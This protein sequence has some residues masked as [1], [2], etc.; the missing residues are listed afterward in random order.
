MEDQSE[1]SQNQSTSR[2]NRPPR[3]PVLGVGDRLG[4]GDSYIVNDLLPSDIAD[5]VF[6]KLKE[7]VKWQVMHHRGGEV[8]RLVAVEGEVGQDGSFP[9]YRHPADESPPL[10]PFSP[11]VS[12]IR[13][14]VQKVVQHPVNH[15]LIQFY[16][17]GKDYISDHSDKTIDVVR[18]SNIVNVSM[19]AQRVMTLKLKKDKHKGSDIDAPH[20]GEILPTQASNVPAPPRPSQKIPLPHNSMLV[21]GLETNAKW[22]HGINHDNRPFQTKSPEEQR[23]EGGRISLTFRH[24][25]TFLSKD[26]AFIWG[27]GAKGKTREEAGKVIFHQDE[28][29]KLLIAFGDE[30]QQSDFDWDQ[31]Y[32]PGFDVLHLTSKEGSGGPPS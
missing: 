10:L 2:R 4:A 28:V 23:E 24:I 29:E 17:S 8:P 14:Y 22:L 11:T 16:R 30:N 12:L 19:G 7:E 5:N 25:G 31:A 1:S 15:V 26:E 13:E 27:Q 20:E 9:V 32:G 6:H 21:M 18:G 3:P